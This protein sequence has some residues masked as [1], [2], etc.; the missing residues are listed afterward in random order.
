MAGKH[1]T[2]GG[3][4]VAIRDG[5]LVF[6]SR[7]SGALTG[8]CFYSLPEQYADWVDTSRSDC[9]LVGLLYAAMYENADLHIS[10]TVS[11]RLLF[12]VN[13]YVVPMMNGLEP[14][15]AK[16]RITAD[17][18]SSAANPDAVH[19]G[20]GF[21]GG[22]DSFHTIMRRG[23]DSDTPEKFRI[24]TLFFFNVGSHG[25]GAA[26]E[27]QKWLEEKFHRRYE[28]LKGFAEEK[29]VPFIPVNSNIHSFYRTGHLQ[30]DTPASIS[31]ALFASRKLA[32]YYLASPGY[33]YYTLIRCSNTQ[34][35][36]IALINDLILPHL[37]TESFQPIADGG[38]ASRFDKTTAIATYAP[39]RK[40]LDVCGNPQTVSG[41]CSTCFK[42]KRTML[43][44]DMLGLLNNFS[45]VFDLSKFDVRT[46]RRYIAEVLNRKKLD[47]FSEDICD[48]ARQWN[49][50][51]ASRTSLFLRLYM[52]FTESAPFRL[53]RSLKQKLRNFRP[54]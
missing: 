36:E 46:K 22:I 6:S 1:I 15:L 49:Y 43:T 54:N 32:H 35:G 48:H 44:L 50:D 29:G 16:I 25:M 34:N 33:T 8:E 23:M 52:R 5:E 11:E 41:N 2:A 53:L 37:A 14:S 45:G 4:E 17:A 40:Y 13:E 47:L 7:I 20:T 51:L 31:A 42:C 39:T 27:R 18:V 26:S 21:S 3:P 24:D 12:T 10:G 28:F 38:N 30:N 19:N 9:F